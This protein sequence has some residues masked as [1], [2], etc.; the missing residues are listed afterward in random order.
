MKE[1]KFYIGANMGNFD[2]KVEGECGKDKFKSLCIPNYVNLISS[3]SYKED[4]SLIKIDGKVFKMGSG[5][6]MNGTIKDRSKEKIQALTL[7]SVVRQLERRKGMEEIDRVNVY[8][9]VGL[10]IKDYKKKDNIDYYKSLFDKAFKVEYR[11]FDLEIYFEN[12]NVVPEG[13]CYYMA[14]SNKYEN[15]NNVII[16]D[17][18]S[19][20]IDVVRIKHGKAENPNSI[21]YMGTLNLI[22]RI[23]ERI[24]SEEEFKPSKEQ[25]D[26]ML[27]DGIVKVGKKILNKKN[28]I[29][30]IEG[31][32]NDVHISLKNEFNDIEMAE[33]II[34]FGGGMYQIGKYLEDRMKNADIERFDEPEY[35]NASSYFKLS[36][37]SE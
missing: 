24:D 5:E 22:K 36:F 32:Y 34:A 26:E 20:T 18:G 3:E 29:D 33:K 1:I 13:Y 7:Y 25:V 6:M 8:L 17:F 27:V 11:N 21:E 14:N 19:E 30:I 31:Y 12:V 15:N 28:Y 10:P 37:K 35:I 4:D 2:T 9:C 16:I 23:Q